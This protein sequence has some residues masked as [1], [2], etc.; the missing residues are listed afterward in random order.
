MDVT[1]AP[2]WL[3]PGDLEVPVSRCLGAGPA[4]IQDWT[5]HS[6]L[7]GTSQVEGVWR[8]T[9]SA[10]VSA[11]RRPWSMILKGWPAPS[12]GQNETSMGW[13]RRELD[14]Y[15]SGLL[16]DLPGGIS[17]PACYGDEQRSDGSAWVWLED[18]ANDASGA[19]P[20]ERHA[21]HARLLGRLNGAW[22]AGRPLP[23][24]P[25]LS[26]WWIRERV[27]TARPFIEQFS[28]IADHPLMR[29]V[30]PPPVAA[31]WMRLWAE[32]EAHL[33]ALDRLPQTFCHLDAFPRN[34]FTRRGS[35]GS[36]QTVLIDW[37]FAGIA[38]LGE[39][40]T[41]PI[42]ASVMFLEVPV[43]EARHVE[44]LAIDGYLDG[45]RDAGWHGDPDDIRRGYAIAAAL[46][47]GVGGM[48]RWVPTLLNEQV[49]PLAER[50]LGHP[51]EELVTAS[52]AV[53]R[54][55]ADLIPDA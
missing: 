38:A 47:Y 7:G 51:F 39:E 15:R 6:L 2:D 14:L 43:G 53:Q 11:A 1:D 22:V 3:T 33:A 26:R 44:A 45:L 4:A 37:A 9:G 29:R 25:S 12:P 18:V 30:Y 48:G 36:D 52:A 42:V 49:H 21:S 41:S 40:L 24:V 13:P 17:A 46:R 20:L 54:W 35:D 34:A 28:S 10:R 50:I 32:R 55:L 23:N 8:V 19:W 16:G 31:A 27:E 5:C